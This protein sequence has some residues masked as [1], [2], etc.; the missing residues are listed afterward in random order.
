MNCVF[1][2]EKEKRWFVSTQCGGTGF[3]SGFK[4]SEKN[5]QRPSRKKMYFQI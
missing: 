4:F 2:Y 3:H 5:D 1:S